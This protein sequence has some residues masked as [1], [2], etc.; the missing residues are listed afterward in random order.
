MIQSADRHM[1]DAEVQRRL[2]ELASL[3]IHPREQTANRTPLARA[4][5]VYQVLRATSGNIWPM[6]SCCSSK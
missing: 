6:K 4:E 3:K 5:R 2:E 1:S